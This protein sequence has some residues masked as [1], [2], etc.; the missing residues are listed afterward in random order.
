MND[1]ARQQ[2]RARRRI[3]RNICHPVRRAK[4]TWQERISIN[5]NICHGKPCIKGTRVMV[6]VLLD[7]LGEGETVESIARGYCVTP[8]DIHAAILFA[9]ELAKDRF[10]P[11]EQC[12]LSTLISPI[13]SFF[14]RKIIPD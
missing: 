4:M 3:K 9:A 8:D 5:P 2:G 13:F 7:N 6:S 11:L 14:H 1:L 10:I 12:C